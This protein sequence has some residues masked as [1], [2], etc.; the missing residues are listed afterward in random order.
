MGSKEQ[1]FV[2]REVQLKELKGILNSENPEFI[3]VYGRRR[4]GKTF[5]IK[6]AAEDDFTF[7]FTASDNITKN[8]QLLNFAFEL[9]KQFRTLENFVFKT[10]FEAFYKLGELL[11]SIP[12]K[13]NK[14]IFLDEIP[15]AD[16]PKSFFLP[17]LENFWNSRCAFHGDIKLIVCGSATS[18]I[19]NKIISNR[20]GLYGRITHRFKIDPFNL[21]ETAQYFQ[22][23]GYKYSTK[24]MTEIYMIMGGIPYYF[25]LLKK[26]ESISQNIDRL[27]FSS[28]APLAVEFT[29]LFSSL[30]KKPT[31]YIKVIKELAK[32][33]KGLTR[34]DLIKR[35]NLRGNGGFS[36]ILK[37]LEECGFIRNYLPFEIN[38]RKK[39]NK[40]SVHSLFQ[41]IDLYSLFY[42]RFINENKYY[43]KTFWSTNYRTPVLNTWRG[44]SFE[45]LCLLHI[46]QIKESLG[47][48]GV[49]SRVCS[50]TGSY[51][52]DK[53]QIDL[54]IV[55][56]DNVLNI[57]EMKYST[58]KFS[59]TKRYAEDLEHK[60]NVFMLATKAKE[61]P[62]ITFITNNG[63]KKNQYSGIVQKEVN[64]LQLFKY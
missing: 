10:W 43:N 37:E 31:L 39:T 8:Q 36:T 56:K 4:V 55:R 48:S 32:V 52:G 26:G 23:Y 21:Y 2:G 45:K 11:N 33:G 53:A 18:W 1:I 64:L 27:F 42:L 24:D 9:R 54:I 5:L 38:S 16:T 29:Y 47:I 22:A 46:S 19:L 58:D 13:R 49:D 3:V 35:L 30:Y 40:K 25:S 6:K 28:E 41:L 12:E 63:I 51:E 17:A 7:Y 60:L 61:T 57:C 50:W 62:V 44:L 34:Q 20:G 14:I 15:W 59:I